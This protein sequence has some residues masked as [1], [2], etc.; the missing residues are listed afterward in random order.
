M[1]LAGFIDFAE[2]KAIAHNSCAPA[3][4]ESNHGKAP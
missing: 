2:C 1:L 4:F 3:A